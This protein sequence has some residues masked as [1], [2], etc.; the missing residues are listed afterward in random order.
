MSSCAGP[1]PPAPWRRLARAVGGEEKER[2]VMR[3]AAVVVVLV[4]L[5]FAGRSVLG[6]SPAAAHKNAAGSWALFVPGEI[7]W[8]VG[9]DSLAPG[10][11][12]AILEGDPAAEGF[13]TMRLMVPDGY[14]V[15]PHWHP[16]TERLTII[17]G[18]LNLGTG[19]RFDAAATRALPAGT[20][21]SMPPK[22]THFAWTT[23][24]TVL[25]LSSI[26]PWQVVYVDPADDPRSKHR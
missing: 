18:T 14:R 1:D 20:Y 11:K 16:K 15:A 17:S 22:M 21:S 12:V 3:K 8:K 26:G 6:K 4:L 7:E 24:E 25:Q 5:G 9:P 23:G 19:D 2:I 13:F 10:A